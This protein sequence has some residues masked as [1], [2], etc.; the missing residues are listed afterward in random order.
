MNKKQKTPAAYGGEG[1]TRRSAS[2]HEEIGRIWTECGVSNEWAPLK[3][4]L[5][6]RPGSELDVKTDPNNFQMLAP[7]ELKR[8]R[9]QHNALVEAYGRAGVNVHFVDP[10]R[11]PPPNM[12]F[13]ADLFF[14]TR[15]GAILGRPASTVR[16]GEERFVARRLA[17]MGIPIFRTVRG[18]GT[19]EGADAAWL[20]QRTVL[21]AQGLRTNREGAFQVESALTE[22]GINVIPATLLPETM[23]LMGQLRFADRDLA[24]VWRKRISPDTLDILKEHGYQ[25]LA[26]P[27]EKEG[28][29]GMALNFVTLGPK[30]ILMPAGNPKTRSYLQDSGITCTT[31]EVDELAKAAGAIGCMTGI[32]ERAKNQMIR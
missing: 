2:L 10:D 18:R 30:S 17:D 23:H 13:V 9:A 20:D 27:D 5:L 22:L 4:V 6:H 32:L 8:A 14:M 31:V 1:W 19:F 16:A 11:T 29:E 24:V 12:V 26:L 15:E 25:H 3:S 21:L 28:I 7:L